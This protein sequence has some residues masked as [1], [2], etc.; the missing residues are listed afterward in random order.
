VLC[1]TDRFGSTVPVDRLL[2]R[3]DSERCAGRQD[4]GYFR[5][6]TSGQKQTLPARKVFKA[7]DI[8]RMASSPRTCRQPEHSDVGLW[9]TDARVLEGTD[10]RLSNR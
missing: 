2:W 8:S 9:E 3:T 4:C 5:T 7:P 1:S 10:D 6:R